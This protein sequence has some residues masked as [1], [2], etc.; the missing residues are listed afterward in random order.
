MSV[1]KN[2]L[3]V[4]V[5]L[6]L[7]QKAIKQEN[8]GG[9]LLYSKKYKEE[10]MK[11][12]ILRTPLI[13]TIINKPIFIEY[14]RQATITI[15]LEDLCQKF[16]SENSTSKVFLDMQ[17]EKLAK[18]FDY[19]K[20]LDSIT[21]RSRYVTENYPV[22]VLD[23]QVIDPKQSY[24]EQNYMLLNQKAK[25]K[26]IYRPI[27]AKTT[28]VNKLVEKNSNERPQSG[29]MVYQNRSN[30]GNPCTMSYW[31]EQKDFAQRAET[32]VSNKESTS[33]TIEELQG[34]AHKRTQEIEKRYMDERKI[35]A[36]KR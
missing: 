26:N 15:K 35:A 13:T 10:N 4:L 3:H 21:S 14:N 17:S 27:S 30:R 11:E 22:A 33:K 31:V 24:S 5:E 9:V 1:F 34:V 25:I 23:E 28:H 18:M 32:K 29:N 20:K 12:F 8:A 6:L 2:L 7:K 16:F 36:L 19:H